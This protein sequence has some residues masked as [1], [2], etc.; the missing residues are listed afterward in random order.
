M[1]PT[2]TVNIY[3]YRYDKDEALRNSTRC[4]LLSHLSTWAHDLHVL[5]TL[6]K[7]ARNLPK[8][9]ILLSLSVH[10]IYIYTY[11]YVCMYVCKLAR[12][13]I[14]IVFTNNITYI[15]THSHT[16]IYDVTDTLTLHVNYSRF[17]SLI[18]YRT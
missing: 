6:Y 11:S 9:F 4:I 7:R 16:Y 8:Y 10:I 14:L 1:R 13:H 3:L 2:A 12:V 15:S 18:C 17:V 5:F